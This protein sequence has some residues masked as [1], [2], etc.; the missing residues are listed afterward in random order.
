MV[1]VREW[2]IPTERPPLVG[3]AIANEEKIYDEIFYELLMWFWTVNEMSELISGII[4]P[5]FETNLRE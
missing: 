2:T 1:W 3:E 4:A 5:Q